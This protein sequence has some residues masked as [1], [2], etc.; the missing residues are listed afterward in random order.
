MSLGTNGASAAQ[1]EDPEAKNEF[2]EA[3]VATE[4]EAAAAQKAPDVADGQ[5]MAAAASDSPAS[6]V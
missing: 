3:A 2:A 4:A 1:L 6:A 5:L